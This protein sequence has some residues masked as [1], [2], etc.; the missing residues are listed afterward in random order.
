MYKYE[1]QTVKDH[2]PSKTKITHFS[3]YGLKIYYE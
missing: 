3:N 2:F 1:A